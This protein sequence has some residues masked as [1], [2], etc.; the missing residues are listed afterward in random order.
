MLFQKNRSG[1]QPQTT[2]TQIKHNDSI[3]RLVN[4]HNA[5]QEENK[6]NETKLNNDLSTVFGDFDSQNSQRNE[7]MGVTDLF[8]EKP[9]DF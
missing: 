5:S 7:K 2:G 8:E 3:K 9:L 4:D 6:N 1:G